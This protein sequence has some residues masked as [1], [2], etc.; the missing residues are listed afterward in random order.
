MLTTQVL[1]DLTRPGGVPQHPAC[2]PIWRMTPV[3]QRHQARPWSNKVQMPLVVDSSNLP[4]RAIREVGSVASDCV[5]SVDWQMT[6]LK[7]T[8]SPSRY[9]NHHA[10]FAIRQFP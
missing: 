9:D 8:T 10:Q 4:V 3:I 6:R 2:T 7:R 5:Q 1:L